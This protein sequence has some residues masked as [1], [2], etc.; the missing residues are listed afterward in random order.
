[1]YLKYFYDKHL[2][3]ASYMVGCQATGEAAI[4]DPARNI[5]AYLSVARQEGYTINK[6]METHIHADF[7]SG[8]TELARRTGA[9][10]YHSAEGETN[11]GYNFESSLPQQGLKDGDV[12]SVGNVQLKAIHTPG[13]TPEHISY[14]LTDCPNAEYPIGVFTGDFV[15]V[16]DVGR[17]D[18][19]EKSVG[20]KDSADRG[21]R[22]LFHSLQQ[23]KKY[24]DYMQ[25]WPGH[26]AGSACGKAL[27]AV[28]TSTVGYE[29]M[30]NPAFQPD[31]EQE[32]VNFLLDGQPEPPAYFAKMK[33]VNPSG[34]TPLS[35]VP[36]GV[37]LDLDGDS[38]AELATA[39]KNMIID[40]RNAYDFSNR[41]L[42]GT[43]NIPFPDSFAEWMGRLANDDVD[44]YFITELHHI[45]QIR[46]ILTGMG[47]D[48]MKG[49]FPPSVIVTA[50]K[51]RSYENKTPKE[52]E[53]EQ[54]RQDLQ[55]LDA[56]YQ[57]E[58]ETNHIPGA[59]HISLHRLADGADKLSGDKPVAVHCATGRR[60][61]IAS[62]ILLNQG[63]EVINI[64]G[65]FDQWKNEN[66]ATSN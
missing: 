12:V 50:G 21:A 16:G 28:P 36:T 35:E 63:Y 32:F 46:T 33:E 9:T 11:G 23:F 4:I 41:N 40:T 44:L 30:Y 1:M 26:G 53:K 6:A 20:I 34:M 56:R 5:E 8:V 29:K 61:A 43:I 13:H 49:F 22:Q 65:G 17:P 15:F 57:D 66:L 51:T 3:Q 62:S 39:S 2:A 10:I 45:D 59:K 31:D 19:L 14:E 52:I 55:I 60:S 64:T 24:Q 7:V 38:V 47:F 42:P 48:R 54:Q 18:L 37:L 58:W 27:G 25:I